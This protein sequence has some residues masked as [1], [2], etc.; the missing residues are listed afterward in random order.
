MTD[1]VNID[2]LRDALSQATCTKLK[3][4]ENTH[5]VTVYT[6][7]GYEMTFAWCGA[8][9]VYSAMGSRA[10]REVG[11]RADAALI[12]ALVN[13]AAALLDELAMRRIQVDDMSED[14]GKIEERAETAEA[15]LDD[16]HS[17]L[18][19]VCSATDKDHD[20][21]LRLSEMAETIVVWLKDA[22]SERDALRAECERL[23]EALEAIVNRPDRDYLDDD[24]TQTAKLY[25][26]ARAALAAQDP[27]HD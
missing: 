13:N 9:S 18:C 5:G 4:R 21:P 26:Q 15:D 22:R 12:V 10:R 2:A 24:G 3:M 27:R 1:Y 19:E 16:A 14:M 7:D 17:A 23:R 6:D 11:T 20:L 25:A 8:S